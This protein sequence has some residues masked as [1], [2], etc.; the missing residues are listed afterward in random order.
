M[1][2]P[3]GK[4]LTRM[5]LLSGGEKALAAIAFVFAIFLIKPTSFC[6]MDE[7]DAPLDD[8]NVFRFNDL[9]K[10]IGEKSQIV[11][12][13]HNKKTME[14]ADTLLGV[15]MENKG[16]SKIVSVNFKQENGSP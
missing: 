12:I 9:L 5:S 4:K 11:M 6:L 15:T 8:V 7:I 1:I 13:T 3:P 2:H 10:I 14:F 16:V